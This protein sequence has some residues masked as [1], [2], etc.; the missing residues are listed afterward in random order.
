MSP[1]RFRE[2]WKHRTEQKYG[3]RLFENRCGCCWKDCL[4]SMWLMDNDKMEY[5]EEFYLHCF[6][7]LERTIYKEMGKAAKKMQSV[8]DNYMFYPVEKSKAY[9]ALKNKKLKKTFR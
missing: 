6:E 7:I 5:N 9:E 4:E 1:F 8:W 2:H 3:V